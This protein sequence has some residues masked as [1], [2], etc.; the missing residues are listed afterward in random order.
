ML[1]GLVCVCGSQ[2]LQVSCG[3]G[4]KQQRD[5]ERQLLPAPCQGGGHHSPGLSSGAETHMEKGALLSPPKS[6]A[7][8]GT[9]LP[10]PLPPTSRKGS[11]GMRLSTLRSHRQD[12]AGPGSQGLRTPGFLSQLAL[13]A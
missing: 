4:R 10:D 11:L 8:E 1:V 6:Q 5:E 2:G 3:W 13:G 7:G 9:P 12:R